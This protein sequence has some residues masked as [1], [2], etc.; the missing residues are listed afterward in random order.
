MTF[1]VDVALRAASILENN[2]FPFCGCC[3]AGGFDLEKSSFFILFNFRQVAKLSYLVRFEPR[4]YA[5]QV[6]F[7]KCC[8]MHES[9]SQMEVWSPSY[10]RGS[11]MIRCELATR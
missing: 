2:D 4:E 3:P 9:T 8:R 6:S 1:F 11:C 7:E 10:D 5:R